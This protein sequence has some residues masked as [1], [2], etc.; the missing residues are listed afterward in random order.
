MRESHNLGYRMVV[1][2]RAAPRGEEATFSKAVNLNIHKDDV[3]SL[4]SIP[5][6]VCWLKLCVVT[7]NY[8]VREWNLNISISPPSQHQC[9]HIKPSP[10]IYVSSSTFF[11][12][13]FFFFN[14]IFFF[15]TCL[16]FILQQQV[17]VHACVS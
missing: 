4:C 1:S 17:C 14:F 11:I 8:I 15:L 5:Q 16:W 13:S 12:K 9:K 3:T 10:V 6:N 2:L 7:V